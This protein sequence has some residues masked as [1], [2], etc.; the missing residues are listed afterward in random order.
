MT[1]H[2]TQHLKV[3]GPMVYI[4]VLFL[5]LPSLNY[6]LGFSIYFPFH[7]KLTSYPRLVSI[8]PIEFAQ[9]H[10][11]VLKLQFRLVQLHVVYH[12]ECY[13]VSNY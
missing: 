12:L 5:Q 8:N 7:S 2:T 4:K 3:L 10:I 6:C 11:I 9:N 1:L 13:R